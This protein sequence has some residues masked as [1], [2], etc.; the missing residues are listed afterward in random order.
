[1]DIYVSINGYIHIHIWI[2]M[3]HI[4][5]VVSTPLKDMK[6]N[7]DDSSQYMEI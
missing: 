5:L 7:W 3:E 2:Y 6:V 4:W 1:M